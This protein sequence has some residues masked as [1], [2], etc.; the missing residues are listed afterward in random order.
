MP[1]GRR[2]IPARIRPAA[3]F[4]A[5]DNQA[6]G[7]NQLLARQDAVVVVFLAVRPDVKAAT[8][9]GYAPT[10]IWEHM[11]E[12]GKLKCSNETFRKH[13]RR[14]LKPTQTKPGPMN[15]TA[16]QAFVRKENKDD[17]KTKTTKQAGQKNER[18]AQ[19][20]HV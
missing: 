7:F 16:A 19:R 17:Q 3:G 20:L 11:H 10:P 1:P 18:A 5:K 15:K 6:G 13:V 8:E 2:K 12:T 9:A 14:F 4:P